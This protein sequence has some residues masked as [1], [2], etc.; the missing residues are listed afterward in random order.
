MNSSDYP[1][2]ETACYDVKG[3]L[4]E[5][6]LKNSVCIAYPSNVLRKAVRCLIF[7]TVPRGVYAGQFTF[8]NT[9]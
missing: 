8:S 6:A 1:T 3:L 9:C 4:P 5:A 7:I 2:V